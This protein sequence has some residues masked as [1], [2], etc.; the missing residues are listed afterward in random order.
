MKYAGVSELEAIRAATYDAGVVLNLEGEVGGVAP[1][2]LADLLVV[3]GDPSQDIA[4]L[5]DR[6]K[7]EQIILDGAVVEIDR[8]IESWPHQPS[9]V[10]ANTYLTQETAK[11]ALGSDRH[12][13]IPPRPG[14]DSTTRVPGHPIAE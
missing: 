8:D 11:G 6:T 13:A 3:D 1:G 10:Y 5:Q 2:M 7:I 9:Y 12:A 4:V 14:P